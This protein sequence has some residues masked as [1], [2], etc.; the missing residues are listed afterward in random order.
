MQ[1]S[2]RLSRRRLAT[3]AFL[4]VGLLAFPL[5][6]IASHQY[7]DVPDSNPYHADIDAITD[8]GVT[9]GCGN[10]S[11]YCPSAFVTREQMAAFMNRLGAL[12][13]GKTPVVNATKVDG[14]NANDLH[15]V[16]AYVVPTLIDSSAISTTGTLAGTITIPQKGYLIVAANTT[17]YTPGTAGST[18]CQLQFSGGSAWP[19]TYHQTTTGT[20]MVVNQC[21]TQAVIEVCNPG[22][23]Y[24]VEFYV[25]AGTGD[26]SAQNAT[27]IIQYVPFDGEGLRPDCLG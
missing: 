8:A 23:P 20:P 11:M 9:T 27:L 2:R 18:T 10:G 1:I 5:G 7:S 14:F 4:V 16:A 15:R 21:T 22:S 25:S 6:V 3:A 26:T 17:L 19:G 13:A 24:T 12:Q